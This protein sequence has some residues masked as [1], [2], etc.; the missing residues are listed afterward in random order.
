MSKTALMAVRALELRTVMKKEAISSKSVLQALADH[1]NDKTGRCFPGQSAIARQA[2]LLKGYVTTVLERLELLRL[3]RIDRSG[4][5]W[6]YYL[7]F[8]DCWVKLGKPR[9][10]SPPFDS[11]ERLQRSTSF[12]SVEP[13]DES[14][15][16]RLNGGGCSTLDV[17]P[18]DSINKTVLSSRTESSESINPRRESAGPSDRKQPPFKDL[19]QVCREQG[20]QPSNWLSIAELIERR[21][22]FSPSRAQLQ[23]L[24]R[25]LIDRSGR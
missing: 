5:S 18:F 24:E 23:C 25:Q 14:P 1:H 12:H 6:S 9:S 22:N 7:L 10:F 2:G 20:I 8:V 21:F 15:F 11:A 4:R 3:I 17:R 13:Q 16:A 19:L